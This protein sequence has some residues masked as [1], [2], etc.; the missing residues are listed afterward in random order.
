M[1][2]LV[3]QPCSVAHPRLGA[4]EGIC[5]SPL[6]MVSPGRIPDPHRQKKGWGGGSQGV[7]GHPQDVS[8]GRGVGQRRARPCM[9]RRPTQSHVS[10]P[11]CP[12]ESRT[13][14]LLPMHLLTH[15]FQSSPEPE[16]EVLN[17]GKR[18]FPHQ[19]SY[20][21]HAVFGGLAEKYFGRG[22][23]LSFKTVAL[24]SPCVL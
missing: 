13:A 15:F 17:S 9:P 6:G 20:G 23:E 5:V 12:G 22:R 7:S 19:R 4:A 16:S 1:A 3:P 2:A 11:S 8:A 24:L 21:S 18:I 10:L 14:P